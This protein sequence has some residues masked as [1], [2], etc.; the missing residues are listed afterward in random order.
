MAGGQ[1]PYLLFSVLSDRVISTARF[2]HEYRKTRLV[3]QA[4]NS[5]RGPPLV[6]LGVWARSSLIASHTLSKQCDRKSCSTRSRWWVLSSDC[7]VLCRT[8]L[9][10]H[11]QAGILGSH[12][13]VLN[14][15]WTTGS[16]VSISS[17]MPSHARSGP[18]RLGARFGRSLV[19]VGQHKCLR[20]FVGASLAISTYS[21][22]KDA[23]R[24]GKFTV[25]NYRW[26]H[27]DG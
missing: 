10:T 19:Q 23:S 21:I 8:S 6:S 15:S 22:G 7:T 26:Q 11:V 4:R 20:S 9:A 24:V 14:H 1:K 27:R 25:F 18:E 5:L 17:T 3:G 12:R 2:D 16:W 13:Q